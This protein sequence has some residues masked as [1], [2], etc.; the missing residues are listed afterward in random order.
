MLER[1]ERT[2]IESE[3]TTKSCL[4]ICSIRV[5]AREKAYISAEKMDAMRGSEAISVE[6]SE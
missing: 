4:G 1:V 5:T 2:L 3:K 6:D